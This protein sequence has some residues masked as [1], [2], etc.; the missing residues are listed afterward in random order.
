VLFPGELKTGTI[1]LMGTNGQRIAEYP[2]QSGALQQ[3]ISVGGLPKGAY[4]V[5][6]RS[7]LGVQML[8]VMKD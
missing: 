7:E 5:L 6:V 8:R 2:V 4:W 3:A 1:T